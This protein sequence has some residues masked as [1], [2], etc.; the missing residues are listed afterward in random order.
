MLPNCQI[1]NAPNP[2]NSH[3][4]SNHQTKSQSYYRQ[5]HPKKDLLTAEELDFKSPES[6]LL[7]DFKNKTNLKNYLKSLSDRDKR[8]Y[9][10]DLIARRKNIKDLNYSLSQ[11]ESKSLLFPS[12]QYLDLIF[13]PDGGYYKVCEDL[14][15]KNKFVKIE[16]IKDQLNNI[17]IKNII[18]DS[19]EQQGLSFPDL[20]VE[21][22]SL[23]YGDYTSKLADNFVYIDRKSPQDMLG[24]VGKQGI[25]RFKREIERAF[26]DNAYIVMVIEYDFSKMLGFNYLPFLA[27]HTKATPEFIFSNLRGLYQTYSNFQALFVENRVEAERVIPIILSNQK[28]Y[29]RV[30]LQFLYDSSLL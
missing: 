19:R 25:D 15:L 8:T 11:V 5:Y 30:D 1:C 2:P 17:N 21:I 20:Q 12:I 28:V 7:N 23:N 3:F 4:W 13:R 6:W 9:C 26:L 14:G 16:E 18:C 29:S 27:R 22:K 24:S 10:K